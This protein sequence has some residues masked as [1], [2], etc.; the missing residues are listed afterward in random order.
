MAGGKLYHSLVSE[1]MNSGNYA[2]LKICIVRLDFDWEGPGIH[3][4]PNLN[5]AEA[6]SYIFL[7]QG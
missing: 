2:P 6:L 4:P 1:E 3:K 5:P 7:Y